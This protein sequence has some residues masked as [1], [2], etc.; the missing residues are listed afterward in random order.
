LLVKKILNII[1]LKFSLNKLQLFFW[2]LLFTI[3]NQ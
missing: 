1:M 3:C 2:V